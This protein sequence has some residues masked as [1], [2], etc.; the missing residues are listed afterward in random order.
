MRINFQP[1]D[2]NVE[3]AQ[4]QC[5]VKLHDAYIEVGMEGIDGQT[6]SSPDK[7]EMIT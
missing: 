5:F 6:V 2:H 3:M 7:V 1:E 4:P